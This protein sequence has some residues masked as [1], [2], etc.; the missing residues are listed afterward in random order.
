MSSFLNKL[1]T[2]E[3]LLEC[4]NLEFITEFSDKKIPEEFEHDDILEW[5]IKR[6]ISKRMSCKNIYGGT[7]YTIKTNDKEI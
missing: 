7:V 3:H 4:L 2:V 5:L 6:L 1:E